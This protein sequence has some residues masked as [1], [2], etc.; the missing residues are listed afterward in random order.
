MVI[1]MI[2]VLVWITGC[3]MSSSTQ[4]QPTLQANIA[5]QITLMVQTPDKPTVTPTRSA[6]VQIA[7]QPTAQP[8]PTPNLYTVKENDTLLDIAIEFDVDIT[9]LQDANPL[10]DPRALQIGQQLLIPDDDFTP[11][12]EIDPPPALPMTA[13][14][15]YSTP[16]ESVFCLGLIENDQL[17]VI[18][19]LQVK[20]QLF[21]REGQILA[22]MVTTLEQT[23]LPPG[24][25]APYRV[26]FPG[27]QIDHVGGAVAALVAGEISTTTDDRFV[28]LLLENIQ[29]STHGRYYLL[30]VDIVNSTEQTT[31]PPRLIFTLVDFNGGIYGYRVWE[32]QAPLPPSVRLN[33]NLSLIPTGLNG[34]TLDSLNPLLHVEA[35]LQEN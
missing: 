21:N 13:P 31:A 14:A 10:V 34:L 2:C 6:A 11:P 32:G 30:A 4:S 22:E 8:S 7:L 19:H 23:L 26:L 15:C 1:G 20:V 24:E 18:E 27:I 25:I 35:R 16:T 12:V 29:T 28:P 3:T 17:D 5:P 9:D 33:V